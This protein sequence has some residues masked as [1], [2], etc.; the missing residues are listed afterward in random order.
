M[1]LIADGPYLGHLN[2][3][4]VIDFYTPRA[5]AGYDKSGCKNL[6]FDF[7]AIYFGNKSH[8]MNKR[9]RE[10]FFSDDRN[11]NLSKTARTSPSLNDGIQVF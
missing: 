11:F 9:A 2:V 5:Y 3:S 7:K 6:V 1:R 10:E 4:P 8:R